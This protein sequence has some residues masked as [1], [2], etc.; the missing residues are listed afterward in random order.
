MPKEIK[1]REL[2]ESDNEMLDKLRRITGKGH[3][4]Q[5]VIKACYRM[6][7]LENEVDEQRRYIAELEGK[8]NRFQMYLRDYFGAEQGLKELINPKN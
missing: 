8:I 7:D 3:N 4:S 1:L 2:S 5:A 6:L